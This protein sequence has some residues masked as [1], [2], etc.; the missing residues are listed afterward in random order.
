MKTTQNTILITGGG[1]GIGFEIA[2]L[3]SEAGN[4]VII[5]GRNKEKL[6]KAAS[7]LQNVSTIACDITSKT[8]VDQLVKRIAAD[9][10]NLNILINNAGNASY[11]NI[12][13]PN[14]NTYEKAFEEMNTN[15]LSILRLTEKLLPTLNAQDN[16]AIVNI[17][18]IVAFV[19]TLRLATYSASKAAL[20]AYTQTLRLALEAQTSTKVFE[21]MPP[22]VNTDFS[23]AIGGENGISPTQVASDLFSAFEE[24]RYEVH[25]GQ[26]SAIYDLFHSAP[27]DALLAMNS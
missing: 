19:P 21:V 27:A 16:A 7:Q 12:L 10:P 4:H 26:T 11:Y 6:Q 22:L 24:N 15:Y 5:T 13:E 18:S 3:F 17:S 14:I 2:K 1:S 23:K 9:F 25:V 8:D 20:H